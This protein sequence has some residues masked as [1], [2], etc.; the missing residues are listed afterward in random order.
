MVEAVVSIAIVG[1]ML[2]AVLN[3]VGAARTSEYKIADHDRGMLLAQR[4][5]AEILA[6]QYCDPASGLGSFGPGADETKPGNRSL[7]EDVDDYNGWK[8]SPPQN[9]DGTPIPWG[10]GYTELV[11]VDWVNPGAWTAPVSSESGIKWIRVTILRQNRVVAALS[12]YRTS[13]WSDPPAV[14]AECPP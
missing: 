11:N 9:K 12:A 4:L 14:A 3:T 10:G 7:Y 1:V 13:A 8:A 6:Q 5:M 2:V